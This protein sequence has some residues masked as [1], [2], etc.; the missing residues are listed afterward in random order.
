MAENE[1]AV[2][3][4]QE[5]IP[6]EPTEEE[7]AQRA[8]LEEEARKY[9]WRDKTEFD[10]APD[11]W[12]DADRFLE[13]PATQVKIGRD[14]IKELR[15]R[16]TQRDKEFAA[17]KATAEQAVQTVK[18]RERQAYE[19]KLAEI[20][21]QKREAAEGADIE[22]YTRLEEQERELKAPEPQ[23]AQ[24]APYQ[25]TPDHIEKYPWLQD[26]VLVAYGSK[27]L[28]DLGIG[29]GNADFDQQLRAADMHLRSQFPSHFKEP[30][31]P[32]V[33]QKV[34]S[35]GL[36]FGAKRGQGASDLPP[37]AMQAAKDFV[38]EGIFKSVDDYAKTYFS[39]MGATS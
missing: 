23:Q 19:A 30:E 34:D 15:E 21:A 6:Q 26:P 13:L 16:D 28:Q 20:Q 17:L 31:K 2:S 11:G 37:E 33:R 22:T 10:L 4:Q 38:A 7:L 39:N 9:G 25:P 12:V 35:G 32:Q 5:N 8:E 24:K 14:T 1:G 27:A 3:E 18:E 36:G 29:D